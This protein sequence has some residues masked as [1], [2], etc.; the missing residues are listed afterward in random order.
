LKVNQMKLLR[1]GGRRV[2][3][4]RTEQGYTAFDDHCTH[5]GGSLAGGVMACDTVTCPWHGSQF[6]VRTGAVKSG[7]A[8][9]PIGVYSVEQVGDGVRLARRAGEPQ[10]AGRR[11]A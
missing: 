7:P 1:V 6:D 11:S 3:L 5:R 10:A 4:A 8:E 9:E 2:V